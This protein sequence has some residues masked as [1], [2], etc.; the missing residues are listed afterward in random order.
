[1]LLFFTNW[2]FVFTAGESCI[3]L[4]D[5]DEDGKDDILFGAANGKD[6]NNV[7]KLSSSSYNEAKKFCQTIGTLYLL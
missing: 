5:I 4:L 6:M 3:R 2:Q 1:M 7:L